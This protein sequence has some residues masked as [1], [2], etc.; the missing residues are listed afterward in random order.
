MPWRRAARSA[1]TP[2]ASAVQRACSGCS[3]PA[4]RRW[5]GSRGHS[6][7]SCPTWCAMCARAWLHAP[8]QTAMCCYLSARASN[9]RRPRLLSVTWTKY[10]TCLVRLRPPFVCAQLMMFMSFP[11]CLAPTANTWQWPPTRWRS[12]FGIRHPIAGVCCLDTRTLFCPW[13]RRCRHFSSRAPRT[14]RCVCGPPW[15][16]PLCQVARW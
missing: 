4:P 11:Q 14:A 7:R 13:M 10:R 15:A 6:S 3:S 5:Y 1:T 12:R 8:P 16:R 2:F 9:C